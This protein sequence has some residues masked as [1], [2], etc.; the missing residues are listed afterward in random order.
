METARPWQTRK[1]PAERIAHG[2]LA[3]VE[4]NT[5][6]GVFVV[7]KA[8]VRIAAIAAAM[9]ALLVAGGAGYGFR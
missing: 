5:V 9:A 1:P 7:K 3:R 4:E 2:A 8:Y 6:K